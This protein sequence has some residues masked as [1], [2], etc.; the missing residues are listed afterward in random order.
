MTRKREK[1]RKRERK[2]KGGKKGKEKP[3]LGITDTK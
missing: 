2:R 1:G 3:E